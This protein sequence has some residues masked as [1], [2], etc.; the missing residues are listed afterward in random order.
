MSAATPVDH[1]VHRRGALAYAVHPRM[2]R[3]SL[4]LDMRRAG[5]AGPVRVGVAVGLVLIVGGLVGQRDVAGFAALG[6]LTSAFC[7]P[8][9]YRV[10]VGRLAALSIGIVGSVAI[11]LVLGLSGAPL[12]AEIIVVAAL[13]GSTALLV[14]M[15]HITGPGAVIFVF[16]ATGAMGFAH[17]MNGVGRAL[18]ATGL[19]AACGAVASLAPW[20]ARNAWQF[21]GPN[22]DSMHA[23]EN[24]G[25]RYETIWTTL[26]R[27]PRRE[28]VVNSCRIVVATAVSA[29]VAA[30]A[31]FSHPMWAAMGAMAAMQGV[32]YHVT[33][34][35]GWQRLAGNIV[36]AVIAAML[37]GLGLGYWGAV[38]AIVICQIVTEVTAP[39]NYAIASVAITPM[40]LILTAL[41]AGLNPS[42]VDRVTDTLIGVVVGIVIAALTVTDAGHLATRSEAG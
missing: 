22:T 40:A 32:S 11:G 7:R 27:R 24:P 14:G 15:M 35:R 42:A 18:I 39:V 19:G 3:S 33:V 4:R 2:W 36:G 1:I 5:I 25:V 8:D 29:A 12:V 9:P 41:S 23:V 21:I 10:R 28:L 6:S 38:V 31:G 34:Q 16:A 13:G 26:R 30:G 17:D 20:I 37:L